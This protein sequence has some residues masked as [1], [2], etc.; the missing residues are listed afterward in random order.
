MPTINYSSNSDV[1]PIPIWHKSNLTLNEAAEYSNI[2]IAKLRE[3]TDREDC[4]FVL[5][6]GSKRL[7]KRAKLDEYLENCY[8]I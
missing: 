4:N 5:F 7:I 8:S 1:K 3:I 2:G 6:N